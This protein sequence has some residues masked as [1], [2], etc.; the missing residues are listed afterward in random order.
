VTS[1]IATEASFLI[2]NTA[3]FDL[4]VQRLLR[5]SQ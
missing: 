3:G 5:T 4:Q 1:V 2:N